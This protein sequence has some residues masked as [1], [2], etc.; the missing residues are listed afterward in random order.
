[1]KIRKVLVSNDWTHVDPAYRNVRYELLACGQIIMR[2]CR[3]VIPGEQ[4]AHVL[5][6]AHEGHPGIVK[7]KSRIRES[8][9]WPG[10]DND[11]EHVVKGC[12][13]CQLVGPKPVPEPLIPTE[14]PSGPWQEVAV[15]LMDAGNGSDH[16]LV[17]INYYSRWSEVAV[18]NSTKA[19][20]VIR[21]IQ[22]MIITHGVPVTLRSD[23]DQPF[24][25]EEFS[26]FCRDYGITQINLIGHIRNEK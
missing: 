10:M 15:D 24:D 2:G 17:V 7:T 12:H 11:V 14:L 9:W 13:T 8:A 20:L 21:C 23:N 18:M 16:L 22:K 19:H 1:M 6:L 25:S 26:E 5:N 3:I 4:R